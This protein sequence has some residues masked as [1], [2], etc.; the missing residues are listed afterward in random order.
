MRHILGNEPI[1]REC[2]FF[3]TEIDGEKL[4]TGHYGEQYD[5]WCTNPKALREGVNGRIIKDPPKHEP[6]IGSWNGCSH[7][8]DAEVGY[9]HFEVVTGYKEPYDGTKINFDEEQQTMKGLL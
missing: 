9:T 7:W 5:G 8:I 4:K 2:E 3:K 6:R 1:C